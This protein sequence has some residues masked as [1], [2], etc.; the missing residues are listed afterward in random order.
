[1]SKEVIF[2]NIRRYKLVLVITVLVVG[3]L[4]V[5]TVSFKNKTTS[6]SYEVN[7]SDF[8]IIKAVGLLETIPNEQPIIATI[9]EVDLMTQIPFYANAHDDDKL[10]IFPI[11]HKGIIYR[12]STHAVINSGTLVLNTGTHI[13]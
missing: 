4:I 7:D 10:L 2:K 6:T 5:A 3:V 9:R 11:A 1:M 13:P 8:A 12:P